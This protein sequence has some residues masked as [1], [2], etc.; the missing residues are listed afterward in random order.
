MV[1]NVLKAP[2]S[3]RARK[4]QWLRITSQTRPGRHLRLTYFRVVANPCHSDALSALLAM[5]SQ[6]LVSRHC[7]TT[8]RIH[9]LRVPSLA[10]DGGITSLLL[11]HKQFTTLS[12]VPTT[13]P[14]DLSTKTS[15][16]IY[17]TLSLTLV[18]GLLNRHEHT[19]PTLCGSSFAFCAHTLSS[20]LKHLTEIC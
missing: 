18:L 5:R 10:I 11:R 13:T 8:L 20:H 4:V 9:T 2:S 1:R 12:V 17:T 6:H 15:C 16:W 19:G 14:S 7:H 3:W